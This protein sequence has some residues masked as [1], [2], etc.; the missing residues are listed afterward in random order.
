MKRQIKTYLKIRYV[1]FSDAE[2]D[3]YSKINTRKHFK[4]KELY[5]FVKGNLHKIDIL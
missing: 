5:S 2:I 4:K 3:E 1:K